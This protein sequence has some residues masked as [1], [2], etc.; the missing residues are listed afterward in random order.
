MIDRR[1]PSSPEVAY[2]LLIPAVS[3]EE[4]TFHIYAGIIRH[5]PVAGFVNSL[6]LLARQ[7]TSHLLQQSWR[8]NDK[9]QRESHVGR[10]CADV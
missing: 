2:L 5:K 8:N 3:T 9:R 6:I 1:T 4:H 10:I 7:S